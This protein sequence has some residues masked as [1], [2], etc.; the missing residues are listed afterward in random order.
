MSAPF[1]SLIIPIFKSEAY[2][3]ACLDSLLGQGER[4]WE[5]ICIND[6]SPDNS[7]AILET[8]EHRDPRIRVLNQE[9][10]GVSVARNRGM[11]VARG[12]YFL[13]L[14]SDDMLAPDTLGLLR[15][16]Q[17]AQPESWVIFGV[18]ERDATGA[19]LRHLGPY[20]DYCSSDA[21]SGPIKGAWL[22]QQLP[23]VWNKLFRRDILEAINGH[24]P[25][26]VP[27]N[28]D[29]F[30]MLRYAL[31]QECFSM[32]PDPLYLY[33]QHEASAC[34]SLP[35]FDRP[36]EHY[37]NHVTLYTS[38][39]DEIRERPTAMRRTYLVG[40]LGRVRFEVK[41]LRCMMAA[42]G[43]PRP[44][45]EKALDLA[46]SHFERL[47]PRSVRLEVGIRR[48]LFALRRRLTR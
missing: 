40:L 30:F 11:A 39:I 43:H 38:L 8:Y 48:L 2:L 35:R 31:T 16:A 7:A 17:E 14:D 19:P 9:N 27:L 18:Q 44:E 21:R 47:F 1:F 24:F 12:R 32:I 15:A 46:Q 28:E 5:A 25:E 36:A 41:V 33:R 29:Q 22:L 10:A 42:T 37:L 3:A 20:R 4:D 13:F 26:G 23:G 34:G 45:L 6:G